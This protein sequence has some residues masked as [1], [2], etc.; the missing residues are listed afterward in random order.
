MF[1]LIIVLLSVLFIIVL[2]LSLL[3]GNLSKAISK[4]IRVARKTFRHI[5]PVL[6]LPFLMTVFALAHVCFFLMLIFLF[7]SKGR[8]NAESTNFTF[9]TINADLSL[10]YNG[11]QI[12]IIIFYVIMLLHGIFLCVN[13]IIYVIGASS[14]QHYFLNRDL[15]K[16]KED[17]KRDP[18]TKRPFGFYIFHSA[19]WMFLSF[20]S[21]IYEAFCTTFMIWFK[22]V[23]SYIA[24]TKFLPANKFLRKIVVFSRKYVS[25]ISRETIYTISMTGYG[26]T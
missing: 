14:I 10:S 1:Y 22:F 7:V 6:L 11:L 16:F 15:I 20:G 13:V 9:T 24:K 25:L 18:K 8:F 12:I 4:T 26:L 3:I 5:W 23:F 21:L 17:K 2:S 19:G